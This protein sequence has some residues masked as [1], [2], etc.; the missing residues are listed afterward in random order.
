MMDNEKLDADFA[1]RIK[2]ECSHDDTEA[3]HYQADAILCELLAGLGFEKT[4]A[5]WAEVGKWYA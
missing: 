2:A 1:A 3:A 4:V 5:E